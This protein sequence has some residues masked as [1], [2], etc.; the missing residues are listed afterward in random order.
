MSF[1]EATRSAVR[2]RPFLALALRAGVV[3]YSAAAAFLGR[4]AGLDGDREAVATALRRFA[5]DLPAYG[6]GKR[7]ARVRMRRGVGVVEGEEKVGEALLSVGDHAVVPDGSAT[8]VVAAGDVG[9][10]ALGTALARLGTAD[11]D[12]VAAGVA[13]DALVVVASG[14]G[15]DALRAV[16]AALSA[17]PE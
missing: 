16:E 9:P 12:V 7:S 15:A 11:A 6:E 14:R 4:E 8:A 1:A 5:D 10:A 3:N 2:E 17:V 13:G